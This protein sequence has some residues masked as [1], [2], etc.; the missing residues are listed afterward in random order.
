MFE[1][2]LELE[3]RE[4]SLIPMLLI[5]ALVAGILGT[6][7]Y[8]INQARQ[9]LTPEQAAVVVQK[10]LVARG[11]ATTQFD[12]G[13]IKASV[14]ESVQDP[15]YQLLA[16]AG[17]LELGK[18]A[19]DGSV[20]VALTKEG[21]A[22]FA[23]FPELKKREL[24]DGNINYT[25]PLAERQLVKVENVE[26]KS[27]TIAQVT[28]SWNWKTTKVGD[29][30]DAD[31]DLVKSFKVWDRQKLID[32]FGADFYHSANQKTTITLIKEDNGWRLST[33]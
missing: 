1:E 3:K 15:N 30:F 8:F 9:K 12:S 18:P 4:S 16:K 7:V 27:P 29:A 31:S 21:E 33:E 5:L 26:M 22:A 25:V 10:L 14:G 24:K 6:A 13:L 19:K 32:K 28:Y 17:I 2:E 20:K 11:P 23:T